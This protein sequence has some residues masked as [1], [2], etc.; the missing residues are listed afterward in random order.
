[1][2]VSLTTLIDQ[3]ITLKTGDVEFG[4][5]FLPGDKPGSSEWLALIGNT[6]PHVLIG[7]SPAEFEGR[8]STPEDAVSSLLRAVQEG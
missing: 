2:S 6:C 8:G 1:M 5:F 4:L 7:E 3:V